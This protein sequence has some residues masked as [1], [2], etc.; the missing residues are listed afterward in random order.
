M[1]AGSRFHVFSPQIRCMLPLAAAH[2][3]L[4]RNGDIVVPHLQPTNS[5]MRLFKNRHRRCFTKLLFAICSKRHHQFS[6]WKVKPG[7]G[8]K[9]NATFTCLAPAALCLVT[10]RYAQSSHN[11]LALLYGNQ[12]S[13]RRQPSRASRAEPRQPG[14]TVG[15]KGTC[16]CLAGGGTASCHALNVSLVSLKV[17]GLLG[18]YKYVCHGHHSVW[19]REML[20]LSMCYLYSTLWDTVNTLRYT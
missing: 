4:R 9:T 5:L 6:F 3:C 18:L 14:E 15:N 12:P 10:P 20:F 2:L 7:V 17:C 16:S 13:A 1:E 19:E 11:R 8:R